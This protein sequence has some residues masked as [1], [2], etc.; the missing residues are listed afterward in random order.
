MKTAVIDTNTHLSRLLSKRLS[1]VEFVNLI[2]D[3]SEQ[4]PVISDKI[5]ENC[6]DTDIYVINIEAGFS[7]TFRSDCAG[8]ELVFWLRIKHHVGKHVVLT[9]FQ[10]IE[11]ILRRYP[12]LTILLAQNVH[13]QDILSDFDVVNSFDTECT[14]NKSRIFSSYIPHAKNQFSMDIIRHEEAN[15]FGMKALWDAHKFRK[16]GNFNKDY[17][18]PLK[19]KLQSITHLLANFIYKSYQP[20]IEEILADNEKRLRE[21]REHIKQRFSDITED[22]SNCLRLKK[23]ISEWEEL[24]VAY[25]N[26]LE[27]ISTN[28]NNPIFNKALSDAGQI[29]YRTHMI[30]GQNR[31]ISEIQEIQSDI[32]KK[33]DELAALSART[34]NRKKDFIVEEKQLT[35]EHRSFVKQSYQDVKNNKDITDE[36]H[37]RAKKS[38]EVLLIDDMADQGWL[39]VYQKIFREN[40][41]TVNKLEKESYSSL[42]ELSNIMINFIQDRYDNLLCVFLDMRIFPHDNN[43]KSVRELTG[44]KLLCSIKEKYP[45]IPVLITTSSNKV[46]TY[47][48]TLALGADAYWNKEGVDNFFTY[49]ESVNNYHKLKD[50]VSSFVKDEYLLLRTF[51]D[52]LNKLKNETDIW[53][54]NGAWI[55]QDGTVKQK[56]KIDK[57]NVYQL[58]RRGIDLFVNYMHSDVKDKSSASDYLSLIIVHYGKIIELF[59]DYGDYGYLYGMAIENNGDVKGKELYKI[60]NQAAHKNNTITYQYFKDCFINIFCNYIT[61]CDI[62]INEN[63]LP[64]SKK[65]KLQYKEDQYKKESTEKS[66]G[67]ISENIDQQDNITRSTEKNLSLETQQKQSTEIIEKSTPKIQDDEKTLTREV[68]KVSW[69]QTIIIWMKRFLRL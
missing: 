55:Y 36:S 48:E 38:K 2:F 26:E 28:L 13:Y 6:S 29:E 66:K 24:S 45:Y 4:L 61:S 46:W 27:E 58:F 49:Q 50:I 51:G 22:E 69:F 54:K 35:N 18:E 25:C 9:G 64:P 19:I 21:K 33:N 23:E 41:I 53:W 11:Q 10:S 44:Y 67:V 40:G 43:T 31:L 20:T 62:E 5:I 3:E 1:N 56:R 68:T 16:Y 34:E 12:N 17:P 30:Q 14:L 39:E 52:T 37:F 32:K 15:W 8:V 63:W 42:E 65:E 47:T 60:R 57:E 59:H 7:N